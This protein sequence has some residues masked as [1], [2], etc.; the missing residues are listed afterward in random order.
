MSENIKDK[1]YDIEYPAIKSASVYYFNTPSGLRYEVRFGRRQD[2]ILH[3][4]IVFGVVNDEFEGEEYVT[5]NRGEVYGVMNTI[6]EI[7][8]TF[9]V[10]HPKI[11]I[12]EFNAVDKDDEGA[13]N[14]NARMLLYK[15]YLP[16]IFDNTW[17]FSINSNNALVKKNTH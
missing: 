8:R 10:E 7:V 13:R 5:T 9:M 16:K 3:A 4:T 14:T 11:M 6:S 12:Y 17:H 2:N 15:R 1:I